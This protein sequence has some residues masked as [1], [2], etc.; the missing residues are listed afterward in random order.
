ML[1]PPLAI[2]DNAAMNICWTSFCLNTIFSSLGNTHRS[3]IAGSYRNSMFNFLRNHRIV[4]QS[5]CT[6]YI[7]TNHERG[8]EFP[9]VVGRIISVSQGLNT[10]CTVERWKLGSPPC[11][12]LPV[13]CPL[14]LSTYH[15]HTY[16]PDLQ[17]QA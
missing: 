1:F 17:H 10:P 8:L 11:L 4:F 3:G 9:S 14:W 7:P 12:R 15:C 6:I 2:V 13:P 16:Q 5:S